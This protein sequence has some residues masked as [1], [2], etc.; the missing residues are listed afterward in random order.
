MPQLD[1][2]TFI[3]QLFWLLVTFALLYLAM[4][5]VALPKIA[6]VLQD[7]QKRIDE[8]LDSAEKLR[9]EAETVRDAYEE[10]VKQGQNQAQ[11]IIR[12][13]NQE[14]TT[15]AALQHSILTERLHAQ[16]AE[17]ETRISIAKNEALEDI[18]NVAIEATQAAASKLIGQPISEAEA[19]KAVTS[20]INRESN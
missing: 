10:S 4:W 13:A 2:T 14:F 8:D 5:K 9:K 1:P 6:S 16:T 17:A 12:A 11:E 19:K 3:P 20:V 18:R 7:R 15:E